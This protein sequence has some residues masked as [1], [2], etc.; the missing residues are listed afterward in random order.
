MAGAQMNDA[1]I[2]L[3]ATAATVYVKTAIDVATMGWSPPGW[4]KPAAALLLAPVVVLLLM[5]SQGAAL[6]SENVATAILAGFLAAGGAVG[7]TELQKHA[8]ASRPAPAEKAE[9]D[10]EFAD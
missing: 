7:V 9:H 2:V 3:I 4:G 5:H 6:G 1:S 10:D 8:R